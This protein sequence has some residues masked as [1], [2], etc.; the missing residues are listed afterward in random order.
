MVSLCMVV[1]SYRPTI[2]KTLRSVNGIV[3]EA[4]IVCQG[5]SIEKDIKTKTKFPIFFVETQPKHFP[6]PDREFSTSFVKDGNWILI[7]DD[8]E[9]LSKQLRRYFKK[10]IEFAE[11]QG[12]DIFN[13]AF[14]NIVDGQN[15]YDLLGTDFHPRLYKKGALIWPSQPHQFPQYKSPFMLF[16]DYEIVHERTVDMIVQSHRMRRDVV[17]GESKKME[18][19]FLRRLGAK[20]GRDVL[21]EVYGQTSF[22]SI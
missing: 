16:L 20:F 17:Q 9:Y 2:E 18:I 1:G 3:D 5:K 19:E 10:A 22:S 13:V 4:Y 12:I 6:E 7:L 8:D 14:K 11:Q 21:A 15:L